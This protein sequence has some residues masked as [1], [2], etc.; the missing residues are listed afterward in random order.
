MPA[1]FAWNAQIKTLVQFDHTHAEIINSML[2][3][4]IPWFDLQLSQHTPLDTIRILHNND[5]L[6]DIKDYLYFI[7]SDEWIARTDS[8][9]T[10]IVEQKNN[11]G[12]M[13]EYRKSG[14]YYPVSSLSQPDADVWYIESGIYKNANQMS[15]IIE[16]SVSN[17]RLCQPITEYDTAGGIILQLV[18]RSLDIA[19]ISPADRT[20]IPVA[21]LDLSRTEQTVTVAGQPYVMLVQPLRFIDGYILC[22]IP[23]DMLTVSVRQ[24]VLL[25]TVIILAAAGLIGLSY[26]ISRTLTANLLAFTGEIKKMQR[27]D[28]IHTLPTHSEDEVGVLVGSFNQMIKRLQRATRS[29]KKLLYDHLVNQL[30]PHFVCNALDMLRIQAG[31]AG[32]HELAK[33]A[34]AISH[35]LLYSMMPVSVLVT[36]QQEINN[37]INY[38]E[39]VNFIVGN[40]VEYSVN[41]QADI[42]SDLESFRVPKLILQ[43]LIENA[44]RHGFSDGESGYIYIRIERTQDLLA[45]HVEDNGKG[46]TEEK[47]R[48]LLDGIGEEGSR[49]GLANVYKRLTMHYGEDFHFDI[50]SMTD[51]GTK[52]SIRIPIDKTLQA[53]DNGA[54]P[55]T[56][57][58]K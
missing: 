46:M 12:A 22:F 8:L 16:I 35:Y 44:V 11:I 54:N 32:N 36:L 34:E 3:T 6:Y 4:I 56:F 13:I 37:S 47:V 19:A 53:Q 9:R 24:R 42:E 25:Y 10:R 15:G 1:F 51:V 40:K 33:S 21:D 45:L 18:T 58:F 57:I 27:L 14:Y 31:Q 26:V 49:I 52:V 30:K 7:E 41:I 50:R 5:T 55:G 29:E 17:E 48:R 28:Q 20:E 2:Y 38:L 43:P 23:H 39:L